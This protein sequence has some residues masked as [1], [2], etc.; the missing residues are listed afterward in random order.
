M[1]SQKV[2]DT[3][4]HLSPRISVNADG[5]PPHWTAISPRA[6]YP[7]GSCSILLAQPWGAE[8]FGAAIAKYSSFAGI[9]KR[10]SGGGGC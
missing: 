5:L 10:Q 3:H 4:L 9:Y 2:I 7:V 1:L 6:V 8:E